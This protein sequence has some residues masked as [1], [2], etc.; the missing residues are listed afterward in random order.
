[1]RF[2]DLYHWVPQKL[3]QIYTVIACICIGKVAWFAVY[4]CGNIW[5]TQYFFALVKISFRS[6]GPPWTNKSTI[7]PRRSYP[8]YIGNHFIEWVTSYWTDNIFSVSLF[9]RSFVPMHGCSLS[10]VI[11]ALFHDLQLNLYFC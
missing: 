10:S 2:N 6:E 1:M 4:I 7:C 11:I 8:F 5:N 9:V 3:P